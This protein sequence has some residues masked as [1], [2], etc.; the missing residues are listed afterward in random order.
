VIHRKRL[1]TAT[2]LLWLAGWVCLLHG[3]QTKHGF[4][5]GAIDLIDWFVIRSFRAGS[6]PAEVQ[7]PQHCLKFKVR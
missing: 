3:L 6:L 1:R 4:E 7:G 5:Q 2:A